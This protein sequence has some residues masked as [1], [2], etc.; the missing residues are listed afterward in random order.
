MCSVED[1]FPVSDQEQSVSLPLPGAFLDFLNNNGLDPSIY[2]VADTIPRYVRLKPGCESLLADIEAELR[3]KLEEV[4]WLPGFFSIPPHIQIAG[5]KAYQQ[6]VIYGMDAASGAAVSAL[7]V[8]PGDHVLDLCA[9]PGAKLCML[10]DLLGNSGSLTGVDIARHR[11]AACCTMLQK[12]A[13]G[14][15]CRLFV[16]DGTT[17][18]LLPLRSCMDIKSGA[19]YGADNKDIFTEWTSKRSW[20]DRKKAFKARNANSSHQSQSTLEPELIYYGRHSGVV[21]LCKSE[22]F[23]PR[24]DNEPSVSGYDRV[25][26]LGAGPCMLSMEAGSAYRPFTGTKSVLV[27]AE[28]THDGSVKHIQKFAFWGWNTLQHRVLDAKRTDTLMHLQLHLLTNGFRLLRVGGSLVYS[29]CSL[30]VA[31]NEHVVEHFLARNSSAELREVDLADKWPCKSGRIPKT[32]RFDPTTSKTS[33]L[34]IAKFTKLT[35]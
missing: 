3:C 25:C 27:D 2:A 13:L 24:N 33:G 5:S 4:V 7:D 32:I 26:H 22:L 19:A 6:G 31:Q 10:S 20:K 28:C 29:T 35:T 11:L 34:F 30:T 8:S 18:S 12:Y 9:A 23:R 1:G 21:G 16:A 15:C 17:F 14:D